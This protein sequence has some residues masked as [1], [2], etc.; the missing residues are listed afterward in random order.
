MRTRLPTALLALVLLVFVGM[1]SAVTPQRIVLDVDHMTCPACG[2]TIQAALKKEP[3]VSET[4]VDAKAATVTV[5][6]DAELTS[7]ERIAR[8]ISEA[9]F[10]AKVRIGEH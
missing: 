2:L 8:I 1:A 3:G 10:P 6:L 4:Q 9:G 7:A 5:T